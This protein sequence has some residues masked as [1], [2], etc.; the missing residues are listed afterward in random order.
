MREKDR[1]TTMQN[2]GVCLEALEQNEEEEI[3]QLYYR[4]IE[5]I[6]ELDYVDF[7]FP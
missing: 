3:R 4:C 5:E 6:W 1:T 7:K 2:S